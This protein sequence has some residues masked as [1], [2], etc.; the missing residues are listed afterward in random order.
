VAVVDL[1]EPVDAEHERLGPVVD[2][3][4]HA[5]V[6]ADEVSGSPGAL[7]RRGP[8][9]TERATFTALGSSKPQGRRGCWFVGCRVVVLPLAVGVQ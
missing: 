5:L 8:L 9:R 6:H 7:L 2:E 1:D 3:A 4:G